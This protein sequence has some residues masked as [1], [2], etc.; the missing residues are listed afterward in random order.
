MQPCPCA[1]LPF[2]WGR[3]DRLLVLEK[4]QPILAGRDEKPVTGDAVQ[5]DTKAG[6]EPPGAFGINARPHGDAIGFRRSEECTEVFEWVA[7]ELER[8]VS[9]DVLNGKLA[10]EDHQ[11]FRKRIHMCRL[12]IALEKHRLIRRLCGAGD[13]NNRRDDEDGSATHCATPAATL[14]AMR[15]AWRAMSKA[16]RRLRAE[17]ARER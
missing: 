11:L 5:A 14:R 10:R 16:H 15:R 13:R 7:G 1:R 3:G 8:L 6:C 2:E 17:P 4:L 9:V 12:E